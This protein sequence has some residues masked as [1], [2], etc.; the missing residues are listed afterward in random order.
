MTDIIKD[1]KVVIEKK[2]GDVINATLVLNDKAVIDYV[3]SMIDS[4]SNG[5]TD[6]YAP[7]VNDELF[8]QMLLRV[9]VEIY[10]SLQ[11]LEPNVVNI[12]KVNIGGNNYK[13]SITDVKNNP[14]IN[15]IIY[16]LVI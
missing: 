10:K 4:L 5:H 14:V 16:G 13:I 11:K 9:V 3:K 7:N 6:E 8:N 12:V 15:G 2:Q 1:S